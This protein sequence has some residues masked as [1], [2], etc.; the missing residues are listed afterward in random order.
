MRF[1]LYIFAFTFLVAGCDGNLEDLK[2]TNN[3]LEGVE[4]SKK[5]NKPI[6][7]YFWTHASRNERFFKDFALSKK[8]QKKLNENFVMVALSVTERKKLTATEIENLG[9][10]PI[11]ESWRDDFLKS[12]R[13]GTMNNYFQ[14]SLTYHGSTFVFAIVDSDGSW[15]IEP[16]QDVRGGRNFF[17]KKLDKGLESWENCQKSY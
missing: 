7:L 17:L 16:F 6:L 13:V 14:V 10:I 1:S 3:Y 11:R 8:I 12:K 9:K 5:L 2:F 4:L 15:L